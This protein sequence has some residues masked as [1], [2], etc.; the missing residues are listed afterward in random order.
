MRK[1][2]M[3]IGLIFFLAAGPFLLASEVVEEIVAIVNDEIITLSQYKK[4]HD[5]LYQMLKSQLE[6]EEFEK[7]YD[8]MKKEILDNIINDLLLLQMAREKGV[9]VSEQVKLTLERIKQDNNL[10]SDEVLKREMER[11]GVDFDQFVKQ[12]EEDYLKQAVIFSEVEKYIVIDDSEIVNYYKLHPEEFTEPEEFRLRAIYISTEGKTE[13]E[14]ESK[15][16]EISEKVQAGDDLASLASQYSDGP[17]KESQ[18]DLGTF[19]KGQLEK[20]L[21]EAV[22]KLKIGEIT[23]WLKGRNGWYLLKL[24][25]KKESRLRSFEEVKKNVEEK[26][27]TEKRQKKVA[28]F[29]KKIR[30]ESY[31]KIL[32]PNPLDF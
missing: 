32:R 8:K 10:E 26:L 25:E 12:M 2:R 1:K 5:L 9:N 28:E 20:S 27:A 6:G 16:K 4:Q 23:P 3:I 15:K 22:E 14:V 29:L 13:E 31:I 19:K 30:E 18:G 11:Q 17:G 21:E 24:E 7:Q